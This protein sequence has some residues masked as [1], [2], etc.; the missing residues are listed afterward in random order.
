MKK[1]KKTLS[2]KGFTLIELILYIALVSIFITGAIF[3]AWDVVYGREKAFQQ[4]IVEQNTRSA[5]ARVA[6]EIRHAE[7]IQSVPADQIVLDNDGS[8]TTIALSEGTVQITTGDAGPYDLTSNQVEVTA[9]SFTDLSSSDENSKD[10][11]VSITVRQTQAAVSGQF[12]AQT[13]MS[14]SAELNSQFNQSRSFLLDGSGAYLSSNNRSILG[15]TIQN[16]GSVDITLDQLT[17]SWTGIAGGENITEIQIGSGTVE[18]TGSQGSGSTIDFTDYTLTVAAGVV[19]IDNL[20]FDSNMSDAE[21]ELG[22]ALSDG[23]ISKSTLILSTSPDASPTPTPTPGPSPTPTPT[24]TS[25]DEHCQQQY[26]LPGSCIKQKDCDGYN[27][28]RIYE[29]N[30]PNICCCQ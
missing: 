23:S 16:T 29:C 7:D 11:N 21:V 1:I 26:S 19:D 25:C 5:L 9:L 10:I 12:E 13:T 20:D 8:T 18:W 22:F 6:Y 30:A 17:I 15:L 24:P 3:F 4:Q 2:Q 14:V 27:E 28:G